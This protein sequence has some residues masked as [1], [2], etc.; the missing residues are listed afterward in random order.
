M[1]V[2]CEQCAGSEVYQKSVFAW[3]LPAAGQG[4][5]AFGSMTVA[6]RDRLRAKP[7]HQAADRHRVNEHDSAS[8]QGAAIPNSLVSPAT[9]RGPAWIEPARGPH[10]PSEATTSE[11]L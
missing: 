5:R 10:I 1:Q 2:M 6:L 8:E 4:T 11:T 3:V 7:I 9:Q